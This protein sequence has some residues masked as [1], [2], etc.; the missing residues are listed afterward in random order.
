MDASGDGRGRRGFALVLSQGGPEPRRLVVRL[1]AAGLEAHVAVG[2]GELRRMGEL[3][4]PDVV[5]A[6]SDPGIGAWYR[7]PVLLIGDP[8]RAA[9][10]DR[11][12]AGV[13]AALGFPTE[14]RPAPA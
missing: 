12:V 8:S 3:L 6:E 2:A 10:C 1:L 5:L 7:G 13:L 14:G 9:A 11:A 4:Q